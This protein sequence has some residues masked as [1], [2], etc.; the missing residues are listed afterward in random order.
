M[1]LSSFIYIYN[2]SLFC[3]SLGRRWKKSY[4]S[5]SRKR[6]DT[7]TIT[8]DETSNDINKNV[9]IDNNND[10]DN[11]DIKNINKTDFD[12]H[13][14]ELSYVSIRIYCLHSIL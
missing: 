10:V 8:N 9:L 14:D 11:V 4:N 7:I 12:E 13:R 6:K 3:I 5:F 1:L 2:R